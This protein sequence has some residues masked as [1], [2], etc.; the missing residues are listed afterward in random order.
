MLISEI[1]PSQVINQ[2]SV[3]TLTRTFYA[4]ILANEELGPVI[5]RAVPEGYGAALFINAFWSSSAPPCFGV[6]KGYERRLPARSLEFVDFE[7]S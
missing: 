7:S 2:A 6:G 3:S 5:R 4:R 1:F